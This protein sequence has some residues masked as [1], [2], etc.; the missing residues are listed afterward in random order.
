MHSSTS[1]AWFVS[2]VVCALLWIRRGRHPEQPREEEAEAAQCWAQA[3]PAAGR[4]VCSGPSLRLHQLPPWSG[5]ADQAR[6]AAAQR[7]CLAGLFAGIPGISAAAAVIK[8]RVYVAVDTHYL[9]Y[10]K[11][12]EKCC[13]L[14]IIEREFQISNYLLLTVT[15]PGDD[16]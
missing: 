2:Q 8:W 1:A 13:R 16:C 6:A 12:C 9:R 5:E 7:R 4:P 14:S 10:K 3:G 15:C 11:C